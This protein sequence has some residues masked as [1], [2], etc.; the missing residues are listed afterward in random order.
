MNPEEI[1]LECLRLARP[2]GLKDPDGRQIVERARL[3]LAFVKED[4]REPAR[5][6][7]PP[8]ADKLQSPAP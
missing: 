8:K 1:R 3:F 6:G 7:R 5:R 4:N 2:D